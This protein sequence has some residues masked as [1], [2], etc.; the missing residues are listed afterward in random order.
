MSIRA[1]HR[2]GILGS[3]NIFGRYLEGLAGFPALEVV[4]VADVDLA[5]AE[6]AAAEFGV[7]AAGGPEALYADPAV[8]IIV[9]L[10]PPNYHYATIIAGLEAGKSVYVEKPIATTLS[11]GRKV[12]EVAATSPGL[13][14][15]APDTFLGSAVQT[16]RRAIDDGLIGS[17][18]GAT[19]FVRHSRAETWHPDPT[20]LF[21]EGGGPVLDMGPYYLA[22][23]VNCLGP[24]A[25]VYS[26][27]R[28]GSPVRKVTSAD[29]QV[30]SIDVTVDTHTSSV[31]TLA[32]GV[33]VST[34]MSFDIWNT[35]LP[36]IEIYGTEGVLSLPNPNTFDG[37]V[38]IKRHTDDDWTVLEPAVS[39]FGRVGTPE[40][41]RRGLGVQD[42]ADA[43]DGGDL[44]V[45]PE[46]AFHTLEVLL[47]METSS[48]ER[49]VIDIDSTCARPAPRY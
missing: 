40:Q 3:G 42:L 45:N 44:R 12:L 17:P 16:A 13:L 14:G 10:T 27:G 25:D 46:F 5:R 22:A 30:D 18:I 26:A 1:T 4:R 31:L 36:R 15:S 23:L 37:D 47:A 28:I 39:L 43:L 21:V 8:D 32:S 48:R 29:R 11:D 20:F 34:V 24:V 6:T 49:R 9:N 19:A 2:L 41:F 7:P 35:E 38:R 33:V